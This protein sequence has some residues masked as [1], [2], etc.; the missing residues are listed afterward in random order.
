MKVIRLVLASLVLGSGP[1]L[2]WGPIGHAAVGVLGVEQTGEQARQQLATLLGSLE[3]EVIAEACNW[4]DWYRDEG[5]GEATAPLH[6]VNIRPKAKD[7]SRR[8]DC[9]DGQCLPEALLRYADQLG[10]R[11]ASKEDR[12]QAFDYVCHFVGDL[13]QPLHVGHADDQGG[14]LVRIRYH[15]VDGDLHDFWD[16][17]LIE[18]HVNNWQDLVRLLRARSSAP[19]PDSWQP[20]DVED[21]TNETYTVM[22]YFA[23][24]PRPQID[25]DFERKSWDVVLQQLDTAAAR[26]AGMLDALLGGESEDGKR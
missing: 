14:N 21:W 17:D 18:R 23:Y 12:S 6:Y 15:N 10:D 9:K 11:K 20:A 7:Y 26:L 13:H 1:A 3:P 22:K 24:P 16:T 2:A 4:P 19:P 8:R 25:A 5:G